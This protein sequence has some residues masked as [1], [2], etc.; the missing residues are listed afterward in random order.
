MSLFFANIELL[1]KNLTI[2][3]FGTLEKT[4]TLLISFKFS[5]G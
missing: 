4:K 3:S 2:K 1:S 5:P